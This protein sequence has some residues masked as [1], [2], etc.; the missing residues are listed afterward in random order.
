[1]IYFIKPNISEVLLLQ[2][3]I[4]ILKIFNESFTFCVVVTEPLKSGV[5]FYIAVL[6]SHIRSVWQSHLASGYHIRQ[7]ISRL[8]GM[9]LSKKQKGKRIILSLLFTRG[10]Q[11]FSVMGQI[12]NIQALRVI[13][14]L[15]Q[16][17]SSAIVAP[18]H[19]HK[20]MGVAM[21]Q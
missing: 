13:W 12:V 21:F 10:Q 1:M 20:Q 18:K 7:Y 15:Q 19:P 4:N 3:V 16:L 14:T 17:F 5:Y 2:C 8:I 9:G 6:T 11:T